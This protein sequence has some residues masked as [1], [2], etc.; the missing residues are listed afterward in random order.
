MASVNP[1]LD[2]VFEFCVEFWEFGLLQ[3]GYC[4]SVLNV[5]IRV[6]LVREV[7]TMP[8]DKTQA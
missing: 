5:F 4:L 8:V 1:V 2:V 3:S 6:K 7:S